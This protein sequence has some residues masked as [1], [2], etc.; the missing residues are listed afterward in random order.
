MNT[1]ILSAKHLQAGYDKKA[2]VSEINF[3]ALNG[4]MICLLGPNGAGKSTILRTLSGLLAPVSG[5][6]EIDGNSI[7]CM[8]QSSLAKKLSLVLTDSISPSLMT[9]RELA[10]MG[11]MPYTGFMGKL[12]EEDYQI[13]DNA[14]EVVGAANLSSR[15]F[16]EL[17]D[18]EK[19]KVMIARALVQEPEL[20]ILDEPTSHLDIKHKV[21]VV[22][23]L[24]KLTREKG[25]TCI[26]ALHDIDLAM[27]GC[28]T[29]MLVKENKIAAQG[30]PEEI[31]S[32]GCIQKLYNISDDAV[33]N[34]LLG[35]IELVGS[36]CNDIFIIGGSGSGIPIYRMLSR[37]G[38]GLTSGVLHENDIDVPIAKAICSSTVTT[39]AFESI[40]DAEL[41]IAA[42][43]VQEAK[44]VIDAGCCLGSCNQR[45]MELL[46]IAQKFG[47][48]IL[49]LRK[50][51]T[52]LDFIDMDINSVIFCRSIGDLMT[53]I[54]EVLNNK[55]ERENQ[56]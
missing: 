53:S 33:Y 43:L 50:H 38:Y 21:E 48:P 52:D 6:V 27:K 26:L 39:N 51:H 22:R 34:E 1:P 54:S 16:S 11:R 15:F 29:V 25:I 35:S 12:S 14:L 5:I 28:Q 30:T 44:C 42:K 24:Q 10:A 32:S 20:I 4:Q 3:D 45:N 55:S 47:K 13:V 9:V 41:K 19:Q 18:G 31:I 49:S 23:V 17:S 40:K 56:L 36:D 46:K 37:S 7:S 2:V 8:K